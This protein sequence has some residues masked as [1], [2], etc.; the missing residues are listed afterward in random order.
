MHSHS[1]CTASMAPVC[2]HK[3]VREQRVGESFFAEGSGGGGGVS[4]PVLG[5]YPIHGFFFTL[6][7]LWAVFIFSDRGFQLLL[8]SCLQCPITSTFWFVAVRFFLFVLFMTFLCDQLC[9]APGL[10]L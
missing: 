4:F 2:L 9:P 6:G 8:C 10:L 7:S 3:E 1:L 5:N